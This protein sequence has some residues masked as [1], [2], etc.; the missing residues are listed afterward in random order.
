MNRLIIRLS[1]HSNLMLR[2][3]G[4]GGQVLNYPRYFSVDTDNADDINRRKRM[5]YRCKQ[6]GLLELD[7]LL[8]TWATENIFDLSTD[9]LNDF[10]S[11]IKQEN[12]DLQ[13]WILQHEEVPKELDNGIMKTLQEYVK[14][15]NKTF[16][17][18]TGNQ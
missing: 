14:S 18:A 1:K 16:T 6:R 7:M 10:E 8:G 4:I 9:E 12:P 15:T 13:N 17:V 11:I 3:R 2:Q 5:L